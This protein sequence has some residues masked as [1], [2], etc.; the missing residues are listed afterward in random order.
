M[1]IPLALIY[2]IPVTRFTVPGGEP[3]PARG[4]SL[5]AFTVLYVLIDGD[6]LLLRS[7]VSKMSMSEFC[8]S[9]SLHSYD[10][11]DLLKVGTN[12]CT[13]PVTFVAMKQSIASCKVVS[14]KNGPATIFVLVSTR[15][16]RSEVEMF[17]TPPSA[18]NYCMSKIKFRE[19]V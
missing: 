18:H 15:R 17:R 7:G 1:T 14:V 2:V 3:I 19:K 4:S 13:K 16:L 10:S 8:G 11:G 12:S 9:N 5:K 6:D